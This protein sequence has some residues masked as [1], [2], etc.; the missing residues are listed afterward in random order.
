MESCSPD[1]IAEYFGLSNRQNVYRH[2]TAA[3][4][5]KRRRRAKLRLRERLLEEGCARMSSSA[6]T[7]AAK[8]LQQY[9]DTNDAA[10]A[11]AL[12]QASALKTIRPPKTRNLG[13][14]PHGPRQTP[15]SQFRA[16]RV[17]IVVFN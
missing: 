5:Y 4:L 6:I 7:A 2:A 14:A 8:S 15:K 16:S 1:W 12:A 10:E 3:G 9:I 13:P 17:P 11:Q